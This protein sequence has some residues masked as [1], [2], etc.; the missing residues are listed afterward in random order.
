MAPPPKKSGNRLV[1]V[2]VIGLVALLGL[3]GGAVWYFGSGS[4]SEMKT[5]SDY[6]PTVAPAAPGGTFA[7]N[8]PKGFDGCSIL[9]L[10]AVNKIFPNEGKTE[11]S[12]YESG[13]P[14][15]GAG[16]IG[17]SQGVTIDASTT[18]SD[19]NG[20]YSLKFTIHKD[21]DAAKASYQRAAA[22]PA[23]AR[24]ALEHPDTSDESQMTYLASK[25]YMRWDY[26]E[27][28]LSIRNGNLTVYGSFR[29]QY[30]RELY[31]Q[32][33]PELLGNL[34][35]DGANQGMTALATG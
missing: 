33:K 35:V 4:T 3:G 9:D 11:G 1:L 20:G 21:V 7:Y 19:F 10:T 25:T 34:L 26:V 2:L 14:K 31:T 30:H 12:A 32:P 24:Q 16:E 18:N 6:K 23:F 15:S 28:H 5:Y 22:S 27:V 17:C 8:R 29:V 13:A